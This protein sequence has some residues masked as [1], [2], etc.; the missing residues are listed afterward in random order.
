MVDEHQP[1]VKQEI[2]GDFN[3]TSIYGNPSVHYYQAPISS[4]LPEHVWMVP[5]RRNPLFT[6]REQILQQLYNSFLTDRAAVLTQGQA[7]SGLGGI[8]KTQIVV[9]YAYRHREDYR[10]VLWVNAASLS[11]LTAD[12]LSIAQHLQLPQRVEQEEELIVAAVRHWLATHEDWLLIVDN[13][14]DLPLVWPL[15]PAGST[16]HVLLT[17]RNQHVGRMQG[18]WIGSLPLSEGAVRRKRY[19]KIPHWPRP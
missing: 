8:G 4:E 7:I 14:D 15:L 13:A 6:G 3:A 19:P 18:F 5:Y 12:F 2:S 9:E 10:F 1:S 17:T 16:G 11:T